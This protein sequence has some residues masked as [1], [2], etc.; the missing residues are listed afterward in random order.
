MKKILF[1]VLSILIPILMISC[2][3]NVNEPDYLD[4]ATLL[5]MIEN[6][7]A[8][9]NFDQ[10]FNDE[11]ATAFLIGKTQ[12][13]LYPIKVGRRITKVE[14][15]F[16]KQVVGDSAKVTVTTKYTGNLIIAGKFTRITLGDTSYRPDTI[17]SKPFVETVKRNLTFI[18]TNS[19]NDKSRGWKLQAISLPEGSTELK[20][21]KINKVELIS[22][23][24][25]IL[26]ITSPL[27][28]YFFIGDSKKD[29][30]ER[31]KNEDV[32]LKVYLTSNSPKEDFV[33]ITYGRKIAGQTYKLKRKL[34]L[35]SSTQ[36]GD[37]WEKVYQG[38]WNIFVVH[39]FGKFHSV[40]NAVTNETIFTV[41]G[42]V[43]SS[44]WGI[45]YKVN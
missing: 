32:T 5:S 41:E 14:R 28:T 24:R 25:E 35:V 39:P 7:E 26:S 22:S 17:V 44:T 6:D 13:D 16:E 34:N 23:G 33:T 38:N 12:L 8:L 11:E 21:I 45:P 40:I 31:K 37:K 27:D 9:A 4:D 43:S 1:I 42:S 18:R 19:K 15:T 29:I 3:S 10:N 2:K 30:P 20:N 36:V